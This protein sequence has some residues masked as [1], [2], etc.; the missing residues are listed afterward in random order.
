MGAAE[1][2]EELLSLNRVRQMTG[3]D[4]TFICGEIKAGRFP[5]SIRIGRRALWIQS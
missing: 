4:T 3:M 1:K 5:R 2:L